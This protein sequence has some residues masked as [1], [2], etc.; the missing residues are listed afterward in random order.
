MNLAISGL[1]TDVADAYA[2]GIMPFAVCANLLDGTASV[3]A[4]VSVYHK[5]IAD[6]PEAPVLVPSRN[7]R[8]S[9][10]AASGRIGTM[11]DDFRYAA[12]DN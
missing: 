2:M 11:D 3:D 6:S 8:N 10:V 7:V 9:I 4:S 12:H 5:V 1:A